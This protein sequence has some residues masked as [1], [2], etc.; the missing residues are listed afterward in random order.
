M[1]SIVVVGGGLAGLACAFRLSRAG[2]E[3]EVLEREAEAGGSAR[4][5]SQLG[6]R[7]ERAAPL[8]WRGDA[9]LEAL[10]DA[11]GLG[12]ALEALPAP[13]LGILCGG[14][15]HAC[16]ARS[17]ARLLVSAP[18]S[19][20]ARL[21]A[22]SLALDL[23][24]WRAW[25][26]PARPERAAPLDGN[27]TARL[28]RRAGEE[29]WGV[30]VGP[31][32]EAIAGDS[33]SALSEAFALLLLR[34]VAA[35]PAPRRIAGGAGRL[36]RALASRVA[37][38][39]GCEATR[40]ETETDGARVRYRRGGREHAV[41]AD[42]AVVALTGDAVPALCPKLAPDERGFFEALAFAPRACVWLLADRLPARGLP[43]LLLLPDAAGGGAHAVALETDAAPPGAALV[44]VQ[45]GES[46][47]RALAGAPD[48]ALVTRALEALAHTPL[49]R[50]EV[51]H[52]VARRGR[53]PRFG[54]G[55]LRRLAGFLARV[56]RSPRLAFANASL[57]GPGLEAAAT[58]GMRA[59]TEVVRGL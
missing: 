31:L 39:T 21:R 41:L 25:L 13:A 51:A 9:N 26:D 47:A 38:R 42:A 10:A 43:P 8:V 19:A 50:L 29:A 53:A 55:H 35:G 36:T 54:P 23:V 52:A 20:R 15:A 2:H 45:L 7:L 3:V 18:L 46:A 12:V 17:L 16:D 27:D 22:A 34:R 44:R 32:L 37:V 57:T 14:V 56:E 48:A 30:L 4:S 5:E 49:G 24:R 6:F 40:V 59:A 1:A 11:L 28:R 33:A 58:S